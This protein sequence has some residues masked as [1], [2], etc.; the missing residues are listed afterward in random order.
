MDVLAHKRKAGRREGAVLV[1]GVPQGPSFR[2]AIAY[3]TQVN[4]C[5][6]HFF[7]FPNC[8]L[9]MKLT[10]RCFDSRLDSGTNFVLCSKACAPFFSWVKSDSKSC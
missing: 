10:G 4:T 2:R 8:S 7:D 3:C 5:F 6:F 9:K 1:N